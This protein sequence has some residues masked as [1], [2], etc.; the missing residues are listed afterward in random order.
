M[1]RP[2]TPPFGSPADNAALSAVL[3]RAT[4]TTPTQRSALAAA[5]TRHEPRNTEDHRPLAVVPRAQRGIV[6]GYLRSRIASD[7]ARGREL[8]AIYELDYD[9]IR[10]HWG[11]DS[12]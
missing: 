6:A 11:V 3:D 1:S 7:E 12:R 5:P 4:A 2:T 8:A 10:L 9:E